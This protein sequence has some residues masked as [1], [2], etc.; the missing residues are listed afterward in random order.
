MTHF[1][2]ISQLETAQLRDILTLAKELKARL[3]KGESLKPLADRQMA[4]IFEKPSTR[5]RTSFEVGINQLGGQA[6]F[7]NTENSQLGRGETI[8]D[9]AK[10]LSRY[11]NLIMIRCFKHD[12][13]LEVAK[14]ASVPVINGLTDLS[15]PCQIM[16]DMMTFEEHRGNIAGKKV[17]WLGD[18]NNV[19]HSWIHAAAKL[20]FSLSIATPEQ[21]KPSAAVMQWIS[22]H[23]ANVSWT[24][25]P[26]EAARDA[27]LVTTDTW[28]SMGDTDTEEKRQLLT[29][30]Q[31]NQALMETAKSEATFLHCLP[32][33]RGDEVTAEVID[34]PQSVVFDE[35][36]NRLH[37]QKAI[38]IWCLKN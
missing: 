23:K 29:P 2:D 19:T 30:Y 14:H 6:V 17:A 16:A 10:V 26:Q 22:D 12:T 38:M 4:M 1:L 7:L 13:L 11:V 8:E 20:D 3:A 24:A 33:H 37:I 31:V 34:G 25:N 9:T 36:E 28:F 35:A 32:A 5:T 18:C 15:H 27:D 21:L